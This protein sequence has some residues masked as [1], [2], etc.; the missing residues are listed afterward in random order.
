MIPTLTAATRSVTAAPLCGTGPHP[1]PRSAH[2]QVRR[3]RSGNRRGPRSTIGLQHITVDLNRVLAQYRVIEHRAQ[4]SANGRGSLASARTTALH[5][6]ARTSRVSSRGSMA[7]SAVAIRAGIAAPPRD[8]CRQRCDAQNTGPTK[9]GRATAFAVVLPPRWKRTGRKASLNGRRC[10][11]LVSSKWRGAWWVGL[12]RKRHASE[13]HVQV[14]GEMRCRI[15]MDLVDV[16]PGTRWVSTTDRLPPPS[17]ASLRPHRSKC[18]FGGLSFRSGRTP[19]TAQVNTRL[20]PPAARTAL[21][22]RS[23]PACDRRLSRAAR[24]Q[25][26]WNHRMRLNEERPDG[27]RCRRELDEVDDRIQRLRTLAAA[28]QVLG[29]IF[30]SARAEHW[31]PRSN[32]FRVIAPTHI[33]G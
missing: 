13:R 9:L 7:Y 11:S 30:E 4:R 3:I 12:H 33:D 20:Q 6:F 32:A 23:T 8:A 17:R 2:L 22:P 24:K 25:T 15:G 14:S 5:G 31:H 18:R 26:G 10:R 21:Y 29:A 27:Q 1:S 28:V 16:V 19:R